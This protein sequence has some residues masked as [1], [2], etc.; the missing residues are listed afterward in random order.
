MSAQTPL[1]ADRFAAVDLGAEIEF[2][3]RMGSAARALQ[4]GLS[5]VAETIY[6]SLLDDSDHLSS[7]EL[8]SLKISLAKALIEQG[9]FVAARE[10]LDSVPQEFHKG[11]YLLYLA[12]SIYGEGDDRVDTEAFLV[13]YGKASSADLESGDLPWLALLEGLVAELEGQTEVATTAYQRALE[14]TD[15]PMLRS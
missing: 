8:S 9:R 3:W 4:S 13:A 2:E 12:L 10:Q 11:Q 7:S 15:Q 14:L 5:G 1:T 6:R